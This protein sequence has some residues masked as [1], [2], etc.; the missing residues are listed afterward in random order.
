MHLG[1]VEFAPGTGDADK[2]FAPVAP[3]EMAAQAVDIVRVDLAHHGVEL[4]AV[5]GSKGRG[6][7]R[8]QRL[9]VVRIHVAVEGVYLTVGLGNRLAGKDGR[10]KD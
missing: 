2:P 3:E 6:K 8:A 9:G 4:D 1:L 5:I 10:C 7:A